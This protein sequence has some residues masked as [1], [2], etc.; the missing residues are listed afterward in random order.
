VEG[1]KDLIGNKY[2]LFGGELTI[3]YISM[4]DMS[5]GEI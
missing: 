2:L 5:A 4:I 3:I 1:Y